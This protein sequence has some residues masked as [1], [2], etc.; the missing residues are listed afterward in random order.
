MNKK[1]LLARERTNK[2]LLYI[3]LD[4]LFINFSLIFAICLW[5][6]GTIPGLP[7][8]AG[9]VIAPQVWNWYI[10]AALCISPICIIIYYLFRFYSNIWKY[11]TIEDVYKI[12]I[13]D[14]F[15]FV[16]LYVIDY[17]FISEAVPFVLSKRMLMVAWITDIILFMF[18]RSGYRVIKKFLI[19]IEHIITRKAG[20]KR[21][22]VVGAGFAGY[23]VIRSIAT[24]EKGYEDRTAVL[25]VDDDIKKNDTN[26]MGVRVTHNCANIPRLASE[27]EIEEIIVAIPSATNAQ[28]NQ[29]MKYCAKTN[30]VLKMIPPLS[31]ISQGFHVLRDVDITDLLFREE[32]EIDTKS[33]S[34]YISGKTVLVTGGGGSI[35]SELCRQ[36]A[37]FSPGL[38]IIFDV[39]ENNAYEL[40][41]ELNDKYEGKLNMT[42]RIGSVRDVSS[43]ERV[44]EDYR[45]QVVFHAAAHKHVPLMEQVPAEAVK[46][47]VFG[48]L[49]TVKCADKYRSEIFVLLSTD[50]AVNPTN[51]MGATKRIT[52][53]IVQS[54]AKKSNTKFVA[55]RFGNV[56]GSNGSVIPLFK[57]Q[58]KT[59]GPVTVT[60]PEITRYFMTIPEASRLVLQAAAFGASGKIFVLDMGDPVKIDDLARNLIRLSGFTPDKDIKIVYTGLR[61][62]EKRFEELIM[63]EEKNDMQ[64]L[65]HD[66]IFVTKP[67]D[68]DEEDFERKLQDLYYVSQNEPENT[69]DMIKKIVPNFSPEGEK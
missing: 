68:I 9:V 38:L 12:I 6:G 28:L 46:N 37:K 34:S 36:I 59:G 54:Y 8:G 64:I 16:L 60:D 15:V 48:T 51:V 2:T 63:E 10:L 65:F 49:N 25:I 26:I 57:K 13:A 56:L 24:A 50:K 42:V 14:T 40:Y 29:I 22:L 41:T 58:I 27:Y 45:P 21:V 31:D 66:K 19:N 20:F 4:I 53:L 7:G 69:V 5:Y 43:I 47:N 55:V 3:V 67:V 61:P 52:E 30:C 1:K 18:S 33:I 39:Y 44:F 62:G 23:N 32:V 17:S 11:A 35:G